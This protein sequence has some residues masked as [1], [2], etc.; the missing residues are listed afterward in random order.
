MSFCPGPPYKRRSI[1]WRT[2]NSED[3]PFVSCGLV[4][5]MPLLRPALRCVLYRRTSAV[6]LLR[7]QAASRDARRHAWFIRASATSHI[8]MVVTCLS[9]CGARQLGCR[10][11][12]CAIATVERGLAPLLQAT[13]V[14]PLALHKLGRHH[15]A[16]S[17]DNK[18]PGSCV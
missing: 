6:R 4:F 9:T 11:R 18:I 12:N 17:P 3:L 5:G 10:F 14:M 16:R 13:A 7:A 15:P 2:Q 8:M 1:G